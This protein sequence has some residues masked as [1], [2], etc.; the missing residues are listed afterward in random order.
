M[1]PEGTDLLD[2]LL[3]ASPSAAIVADLRGRILVFSAAAQAVLGY[4]AE[5][6]RKH[7]HVTDLYHHA[8]DA[9][10]IME[11]LRARGVG[12]P[13]S[14]E[15]LDVN[16]RARNGELI[17]V[18]LGAAWI[19][20]STGTPVGTL[21]VF[22]DRRAELELN[23][24]LEDVTG[25][26]VAIERRSAESAVAGAAAHEMSQPLTAAMGHLEILMMADGIDPAMAERLERTWEQLERMRKLV[27]D[28]SRT[29]SRASVD[30]ASGHRR[31]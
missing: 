11:M 19:V 27:A 22:H 25:Q 6:E 2:R 8:A 21:G 4:R 1:L 13:G 28:F 29:A 16:L 24:R 12:T 18:R 10:R 30:A 26:V 7:L 31:S 5:E 23:H 15:P 3:E 17:P 9:R 14:T 20:S